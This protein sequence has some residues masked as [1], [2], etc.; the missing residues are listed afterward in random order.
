MKT[1]AT[2][3]AALPLGVK[4]RC[5]SHPEPPKTQLPRLLSATAQ[6][7]VRK[8]FKDK[9]VIMIAH[10]LHT[11]IDCDQARRLTRLGRVRPAPSGT[12]SHEK[13]CS[14]IL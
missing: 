13:Q 9:T 14:I 10:R 12:L 2:K 8:R 3:S 7:V 6:D 4:A 5:D 11:V 1:A